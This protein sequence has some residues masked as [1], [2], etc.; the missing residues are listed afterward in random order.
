MR[1]GGGFMAGGVL[2]ELQR[3]CWG[4]WCG[5]LSNGY[6]LSILRKCEK[7][8]IVLRCDP[9]VCRCSICIVLWMESNECVCSMGYFAKLEM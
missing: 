9:L 6:C 3:S 7:R 4:I 5:R 2:E 8:S 1:G